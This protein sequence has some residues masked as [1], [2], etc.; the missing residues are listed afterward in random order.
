M[1]SDCS[2]YKSRR[3]GYCNKG[4]H[5]EGRGMRKLSTAPPL[6]PERRSER[7]RHYRCQVSVIRKGPWSTNHLAPPLTRS[8]YLFLVVFLLLPRADHARTSK[9]YYLHL[10]QNLCPRIPAASTLFQR[11]QLPIGRSVDVEKAQEPGGRRPPSR[12]PRLDQS[13]TSYGLVI[14][15]CFRSAAS[16]LFVLQF[17]FF[18]RHLFFILHEECNPG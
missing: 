9:T 18:H 12:R 13:I 14:F 10:A 2:A 17:D 15:H 5:A 16:R 6:F 4:V 7:R 1:I 3:D 11:K 8:R